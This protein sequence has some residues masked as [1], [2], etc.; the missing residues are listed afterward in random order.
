MA[1]LEGL[2]DLFSFSPSRRLTGDRTET[3]QEMCV[4]RLALGFRLTW[5]EMCDAIGEAKSIHHL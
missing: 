5:L 4:K 3:D 2:Q 1:V